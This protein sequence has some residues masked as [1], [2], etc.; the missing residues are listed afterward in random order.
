MEH[1]TVTGSTNADLVAR[2]RSGEP[3]GAVLL[4]DSQTAGRGRRGR[5]WTAPAGCAL[6]M[7]VLLRPAVAPENLP[8]VPLLG[9]LAVADALRRVGPVAA[10]L[11]WPNDVLVGERKVAGLLAEVVPARRSE[12]EPAGVVLGIGVNLTQTTD[13]LPTAVATSLA[14]AGATTTD[15]DA[16]LAAVLAELAGRYQAWVAAGG[17]A[18]RCGLAAGYRDACAT[19]GQEVRVQ[20][21]G[22]AELRGGCPGVTGDGQ[23][24]VRTGAD[25]VAL[26]AGDVVHVRPL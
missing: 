11:K 18:A 2:A 9:G 20:L 10:T 14:L 3:E 21:S 12:D 4:A 8:W 24:L 13:E 19:V 1:V 23:L 26:S 15:R 25:V 16:V 7:S 5:T 17:D 22:G 6:T